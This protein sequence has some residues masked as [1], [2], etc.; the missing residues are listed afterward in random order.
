MI[1][2]SFLFADITSTEDKMIKL[3]SSISIFMVSFNLY[4]VTEIV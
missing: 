1:Q 2:S 4:E 3:T